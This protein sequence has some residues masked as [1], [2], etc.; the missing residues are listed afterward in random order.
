[1]TISINYF[2]DPLWMFNKTSLIPIKQIDFNERLQKT[3]YLCFKNANYE[4]VLIGNS[5]TSY[6]NQEAFDLNST[7]F[8]YAV[9]GMPQN[10]YDSFVDIFRN[11]TNHEPEYIIIGMDFITGH[12]VDKSI[13]NK[14]IAEEYYMQTKSPVYRIK[15]LLS[16]DTLIYSIKNVSISVQQLVGMYNRKQRFY[17]QKNVK[18]LMSKNL[19]NHTEIIKTGVLKK[20]EKIERDLYIQYYSYL[21]KKYSNSKVI[22]FVP[23]L[24]TEVLRSYHDMGMDD[25]YF[26]WLKDMVGIFG[27]VYNFMYISDV[28]NDGTNFYDAY[29]YYPYIGSI[30]AKQIS[31]NMQYRKNFGVLLNSKN[32][33]SFIENYSN[34][35]AQ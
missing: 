16:A 1:V 22:I 4:S 8:N 7:I 20:K 30:I 12:I 15:S 13:K 6:I 11:V 9:N 33:D 34:E 10:E 3:N 29:H 5:R 17:D 32:I 14:L 2:V 35:L 19:I 28:S 27:E 23:P 24:P 26:R 25:E 18:G 31:S 21:K